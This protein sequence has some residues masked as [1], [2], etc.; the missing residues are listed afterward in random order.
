MIG[1]VAAL[2][3]AVELALLVAIR[4]NLALNVPMLIYPVDAIRQ[5]QG[6]L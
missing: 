3:P 5:W 6:G 2:V 1:A 4:D